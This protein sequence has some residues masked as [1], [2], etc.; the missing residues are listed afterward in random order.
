MYHFIKV[1]ESDARSN[2]SGPNSVSARSG[3]QSAEPSSRIRLSLDEPPAS[4]K[5]K[6]T[7]FD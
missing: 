1:V 2:N 5:N 6:K 7:N 4:G 3:S